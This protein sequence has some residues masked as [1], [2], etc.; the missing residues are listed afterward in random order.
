M[1]YLMID[2]ARTLLF[3]RLKIWEMLNYYAI[4]T[5]VQTNKKKEKGDKRYF[6]YKYI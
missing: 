2:F 5:R 6:I 3:S 1:L 4:I